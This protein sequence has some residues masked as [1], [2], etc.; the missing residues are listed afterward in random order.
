MIYGND[1]IVVKIKTK[2]RHMSMRKIKQRKLK[3]GSLFWG[4]VLNL[5]ESHFNLSVY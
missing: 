2:L 1:N 4:P 3:K 5:N